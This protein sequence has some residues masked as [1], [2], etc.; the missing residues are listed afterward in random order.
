MNENWIY[1][2]VT[3]IVLRVYNVTYLCIALIILLTGTKIV[4]MVLTIYL[5]R[6]KKEK[7]VQRYS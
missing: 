7:K 4:I 3:D 2:N 5:S 1:I 6:S